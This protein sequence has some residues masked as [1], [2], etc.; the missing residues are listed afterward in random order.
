MSEGRDRWQPANGAFIQ[1]KSRTMRAPLASPTPINTQKRAAVPKISEAMAGQKQSPSYLAAQAL[2]QNSSMG[3]RSG[4]RAANSVRRRDDSPQLLGV[5]KILPG[6]AKPCVSKA[7][8]TRVMVARS[9]GANI[10]SR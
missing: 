4:L 1:R 9:A 6:L 3:P 7:W 2:A 8:R 10:K 5:G